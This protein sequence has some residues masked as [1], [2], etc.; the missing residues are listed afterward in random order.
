MRKRIYLNVSLYKRP[1]VNKSYAMYIMEFL[2]KCHVLETILYENLSLCP[3]DAC[4]ILILLIHSNIRIRIL[5]K[6]D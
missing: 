1:K 4:F 2:F 6:E 5:R 3:L